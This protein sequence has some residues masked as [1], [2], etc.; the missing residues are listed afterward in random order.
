MKQVVD[1]ENFR[2]AVHICS[3]MRKPSAPDRPPRRNCSHCFKVVT[4]WQVLRQGPRRGS[5][6]ELSRSARSP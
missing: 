6:V 5:G 3:H 4:P 2:D 1:R